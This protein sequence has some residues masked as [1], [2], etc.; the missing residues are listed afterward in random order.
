MTRTFEDKIATRDKVPLLGGL[1]GPSGGGKTF[2]AL[3][4]ATGIQ[5]V[6]GGDIFLIDTEAKRSLHYAKDFKFRWLEFNAPFCPLDYLA[7]I[8]HCVKRGA[9]V[10]VVDSM[11]HEHEG[12]G[13][14]LEQHTAE[15]ARLVKEWSRNGNHVSESAVNFPAWAEPKSK[16]RRLINGVVQLGVSAIFCFRAKE[17]SKP[18]KRGEVVDGERQDRAGLQELGWMP[19]AGEE[20]VYEMGFNLLLEPGS[21]GRPNLSP[22]ET[23]TKRMV[24]LPGQFRGMIAAN[25]Q[26]DE[27]TGEALARWAAGDGPTAPQAK[28]QPQPKPPG[29]VE[30]AIVRLTNAPPDEVD[31]IADELRKLYQWS[32]QDGK[33]LK[34][35]LDRLRSTSP[36]PKDASDPAESFDR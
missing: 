4:L 6:T 29:D 34:K 25:K 16:R 2:S 23:G 30:D 32:A 12:P 17:K 14:V 31:S 27:A 9:G 7:A 22:T 35:T 33:K 11:S 28:Q 13:G 1:M 18:Y 20:F 10:L 8:E 21:D 3:R 19:I 5:R 26:L 15:C 24:K 36:A